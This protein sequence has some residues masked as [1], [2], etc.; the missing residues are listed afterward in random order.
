M[1]SFCFSGLGAPNIYVLHVAHNPYLS[2]NVRKKKLEFVYAPGLA[3]TYQFWSSHVSML[4][5]RRIAGADE[6]PSSWRARLQKVEGVSLGFTWEKWIQ[7]CLPLKMHT[8]H[9]HNIYIYM[10][11]ILTS[12]ASWWHWEWWFHCETCLRNWWS[13]WKWCWAAQI[14]S[15]RSCKKMLRLKVFNVMFQGNFQSVSWQRQMLPVL[16]CIQRLLQYYNPQSSCHIRSGLIKMK[17]EFTKQPS[18]MDS[19]LDALWSGDIYPSALGMTR[20][21]TRLWNSRIGRLSSH[22]PWFLNEYMVSLLLMMSFFGW[23]LQKHFF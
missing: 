16:I 6:A 23:L 17:G 8:I 20:M 14:V 2:G 5:P 4:W 19:A 9:I 12:K 1:N 13:S 22:T 18:D 7:Q 21:G 15:N 3:E 10:I 11:C